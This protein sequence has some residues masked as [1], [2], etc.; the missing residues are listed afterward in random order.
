MAALCT[1][2]MYIA[3]LCALQMD[4]ADYRGRVSLVV[5]RWTASL[6]LGV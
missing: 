1:L 2:Q 6:D 3:V 4:L 5:A